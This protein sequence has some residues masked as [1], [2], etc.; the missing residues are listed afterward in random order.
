MVCCAIGLLVFSIA[1][2]LAI[3][4]LLSKNR[5]KIR[6]PR[7]PEVPFRGVIP[8]PTSTSCDDDGK[9]RAAQHVLA[10]LLRQSRGGAACRQR[11]PLF[12]S[13]GALGLAHP[14]RCCNVRQQP[15]VPCRA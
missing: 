10:G 9:L 14:S 13:R 3:G 5:P 8:T 1:S 4:M 15:L 12:F 6:K 11:L 7:Q 2:G